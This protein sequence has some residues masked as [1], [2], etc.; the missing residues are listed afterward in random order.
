MFRR[1]FTN[2]V[3]LVLVKVCML[4]ALAWLAGNSTEAE[5]KQ[6][7]SYLQHLVVIEGWR[8]AGWTFIGSGTAVQTEDGPGVVT[9]WHVLE[10]EEVVRVCADLQRTTCA[11]SVDF[12]RSSDPV[13]DVALALVP[14]AVGSPAK[15]SL[16]VHA[17]DKV[18]TMG[19]P[20]GIL[21]LAEGQVVTPE[22]AGMYRMLGWC[23]YGS[24]GGGVF[25]RRGR[26]VGVITAFAQQGVPQPNLSLFPDFPVVVEV[27]A[28]T[29]CIVHMVR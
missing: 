19:L 16:D 9:A 2:L 13:L 5:G 3:L 15:V 21:V 6:P 23:D 27:P 11:I 14:K 22:F 20:R 8:P 17:G 10:G 28:N 18:M 12:M 7:L 26:L 4:L 24:S 25:D 1:S 29:M